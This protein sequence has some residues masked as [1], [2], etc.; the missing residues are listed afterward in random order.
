MIIFLRKIIDKLIL[1]ENNQLLIVQT[2]PQ[3]FRCFLFDT[4][5]DIIAQTISMIERSVL[6]GDQFAK[7]LTRKWLIFLIV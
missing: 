5:L 4:F 1:I 3:I 6:Y 7:S 2:K